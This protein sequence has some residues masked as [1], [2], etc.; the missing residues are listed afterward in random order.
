MKADRRASVLAVL[1]ED[2]R[3]ALRHLDGKPEDKAY[4][5]IT[6][7]R[8]SYGEV[9]TPPTRARSFMIRTI[10]RRRKW[11]ALHHG[12]FVRRAGSVVQVVDE[13]DGAFGEVI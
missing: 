4:T 9:E 13:R 12:V 7:S 8:E 10:W 11:Q 6:L 2:E 3:T 1:R 5:V